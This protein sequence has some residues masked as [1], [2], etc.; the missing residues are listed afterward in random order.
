MNKAKLTFLIAILALICSLDLNAHDIQTPHISVS[1]EASRSIKPNQLIWRI[2]IRNEAKD[3]KRVAKEHNES[4]ANVLKLLKKHGVKKKD[5]QTT[6]MQLSENKQYRKS[7]WIKLGFFASSQ[8]QFKLTNLKKYKALWDGLAA[9]S[10]VS[11][12][13]FSYS[14]SD[15][16]KIKSE[17][18]EEALINAKVKAMSMAKVLSMRAGKPLMINENSISPAPVRAERMMTAQGM[19]GQENI[20]VGRIEYRMSVSVVFEMSER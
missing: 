13:G 10:E 20:S 4:V 2:S 8:I 14:H 7:E 19:K 12:N 18:R 6:H 11:S 3:S 17:L 15:A 16:K 5:I 9:Q 1:G